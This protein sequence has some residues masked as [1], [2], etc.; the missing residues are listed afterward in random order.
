MGGLS[1][2]AMVWPEFKKSHQWLEYAIAQM[3]R[4]MERQVYPDG[5]QTELT[6]H[7][8]RVALLNFE[9]FMLHLES[10][11]AVLPDSYRK[12]VENMWNYLAYSMR[13]SGYGVF[14]NDSDYN[15]TRSEVLSAA[16]RYARPDWRYIAT[17]GAQGEM[18]E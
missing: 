1:T 7:Y 16:D 9:K 14:N 18:P 4:D 11:D 2:V 13:P 12:T 8:H 5:I 6:S 15:F 3:T 10:S 17:N